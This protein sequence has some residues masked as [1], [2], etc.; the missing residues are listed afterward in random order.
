MKGC[1]Y[2]F[3]MGRIFSSG[4]WAKQSKRMSELNNGS[5]F[6][7]QDG[8]EQHGTLISIASI[9]ERMSTLMVTE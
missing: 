7:Q 6:T 1:A 3:E 9:E 4:H 8:T 5:Y 2:Q